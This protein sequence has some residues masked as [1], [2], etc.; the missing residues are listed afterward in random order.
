MR[1]ELLRNNHIN[2][3]YNLGTGVG[4]SVKEVI[5][6]VIEITNKK[7]NIEEGERRIGD[8]NKLVASS[9][10][11]EKELGWVPHRSNLNQIISDAWNW[12]K[13]GNYKKLTSRINLTAIIHKSVNTIQ[14]VCLIL[15]LL[16]KDIF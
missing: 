1:L 13:I 16:V 14:N 10:R 2:N 5:N 8:C 9:K 15:A 6:S 11:A 7:L 3:V 4:F 12:H